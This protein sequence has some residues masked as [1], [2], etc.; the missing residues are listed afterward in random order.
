MTTN[1]PN[2]AMA[3][4]T[5]VSFL[6]VEEDCAACM[7]PVNAMVLCHGCQRCHCCVACTRHIVQ[8]NP[9]NHRCPVCRSHAFP[10]PVEEEQQ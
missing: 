8:T 2:A 10:V 7:Q 6:D 4:A 5:V 1:T 9:F 3:Q